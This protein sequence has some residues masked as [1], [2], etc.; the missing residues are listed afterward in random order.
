MTGTG[1]ELG[2]PECGLEVISITPQK[3]LNI[4]VILRDTFEFVFKY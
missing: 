1:F 2:P 3:E 4:V